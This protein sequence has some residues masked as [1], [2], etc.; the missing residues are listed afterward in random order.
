VGIARARR[1]MLW[2][3]EV[4]GAEALA[5]G[6]ADDH[7]VADGALALASTWARRAAA[8]PIR[9]Y[10]RIKAGLRQAPMSIE[11]A[12]GFQLDNA[13]GLFASADFKEGAAAF[14]EKRA[15]RF[16]LNGTSP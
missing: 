12:L 16:G 3:T 10:G 1:M 14:F 8:G 5:S 2:A 9:A 13:P 15:P 6:L 7:A 4:D 11:H